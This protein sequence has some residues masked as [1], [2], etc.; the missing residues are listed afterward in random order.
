MWLEQQPPT[1]ATARRTLAR[2]KEWGEGVKWWRRWREGRRIR[3]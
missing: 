2:E 1:T 3:R